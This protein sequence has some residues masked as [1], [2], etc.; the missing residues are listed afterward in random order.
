MPPTSRT[1]FETVWLPGLT[2]RRMS[3]WPTTAAGF[4]GAF[5]LPAAVIEAIEIEAGIVAGAA[6]TTTVAQH[7]LPVSTVDV[8]QTEMPGLPVDGAVN[9][10]AEVT[11][12]A[13]ADQVTVVA[14][15]ASAFTAAVNVIEA[16]VLTVAV[17]GV[18]STKFT[19]AV[20]AGGVYS[21]TVT[22][23]PHA[24]S[25]AAPTTRIVLREKFMN[26]PVEVALQ[27][28]SEKSLPLLACHDS[29]HGKSCWQGK[30]TAG[31]SRGI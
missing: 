10:P 25:N 21:C 3:I 12:P 5:R 18:T 29:I 15:P 11:V 16:P 7:F 9:T 2:F 20:V 14:R 22:L 19:F 8:E 17:A 30:N 13:E 28:T 24:A 27:E 1:T 4:T 31:Q 26:P 23:S 6:V